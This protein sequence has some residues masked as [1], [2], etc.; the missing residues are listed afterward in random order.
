M[1]HYPALHVNNLHWVTGLYQFWW[2]AFF[3]VHTLT[4][5]R[6]LLTFFKVTLMLER[7]SSKTFVFLIIFW[8]DWAQILCC[9]MH[10]HDHAQNSFYY[11]GLYLSKIQIGVLL[12]CCQLWPAKGLIHALAHVLVT[13][14]CVMIASI[15]CRAVFMISANIHGHSWLHSCF[16]FVF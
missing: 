10:V 9:L 15:H 13:T 14:L 8:A 12:G 7:S 2:L 6:S 4:F 11:S 3:Q 5:L 16:A 1:K